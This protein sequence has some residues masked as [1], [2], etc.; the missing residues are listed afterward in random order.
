S[1]NMHELPGF[2]GD[3][4]VPRRSLLVPASHVSST[5]RSLFFPLAHLLGLWA[6]GV[7]QPLYDI[8]RRY[9]DF[10]VAH[11]AGPMA[12][13]GF[14]AVIS[15]ARPLLLA[16]PWIVVSLVRPRAGRVVLVGLVALLATALASQVMAHRLA[17]STPA[18]Y[19]IAGAIGIAVAWGYA[20][21]PIVRSFFSIASIG[22]VLFPLLFL[23]QPE[24]TPF[25]RGD[26]RALQTRA[27]IDKPVPPI[28]FV[29]FDQLPL[30][31]LM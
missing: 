22:V 1:C 3:D 11:R 23:T 25:M 20:A 31:S 30:P 19:A 28:V 14:A 16:L 8:L 13:S 4:P 26:S 6:F 18:H 7:A 24:M 15:L 12:M 27:A 21:F 10:F 9:G 5:V 29:V 2:C 17:L